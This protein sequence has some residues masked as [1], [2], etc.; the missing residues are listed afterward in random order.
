MI[1]RKKATKIA[2]AHMFIDKDIKKNSKTIQA[3]IHQAS[4]QQCRIVQFPE[5][6][7]SGYCKTQITSWEGY[8]WKELERQLT[9]IQQ[10]AL[11][12]NIWVIVGSAAVVDGKKPPRNSL[13]V[14]SNTGEI[15]ARYDKRFISHGELQGWY[16]PGKEAI[17]FEVDGLTFGLALCL[18]VQFPEIFEEY[19][20]Q[21]VDAVLLSA[22]VNDSMFEVTARVY[23]N[24]YNYWV[25]FSVTS[26]QEPPLTSSLI[27][28]DG[29]IQ[30][31]S[32]KNEGSLA[33]S[34]IDPNDERWDIPLNKAKPWR[35]L[36]RQGDIYK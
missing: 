2:V 8:D 29:Y 17:T 19:Y 16:S 12:L 21:D 22:Y 20:R 15:I 31:L 34:E 18:E 5:G 26:N 33:I 32:E 27:G 25:G 30:S 9:I 36:A 23:A 10:L 14:I 3:L 11:K 4:E 13:V 35:K 24:L 1:H 28:P 7:L 6:A